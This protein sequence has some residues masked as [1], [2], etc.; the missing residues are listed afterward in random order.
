MVEEL[1]QELAVLAEEY[2]I[3]KNLLLKDVS[4]DILQQIGEPMKDIRYID[5]FIANGNK[6]LVRTSLT[7]TRFEEFE[8]LQA[9]VGYGVSFKQLYANLNKAFQELNAMKPADATITI[10][11]MINGV[12]QN[13]NMRENEVL[14][15]CGLFI[16]R[17]DEDLTKYDPAYV[18]AKIEDW[19]KEGISMDNFFTI[20]F[21]LTSGFI[22]NLKDGLKNISQKVKAAKEEANTTTK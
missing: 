8:K 20:A 22:P 16:C 12:K 3:K 2:Q 1:K 5:N 17:E 4:A 7:I 14:L 6:Y 13:L 15:L 19:R 9:Q 11:N 18:S 21:T 10:Y